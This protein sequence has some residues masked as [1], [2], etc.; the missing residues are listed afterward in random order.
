MSSKSSPN[1]V[2]IR[3][4]LLRRTARHERALE[5]VSCKA[6]FGSVALPDTPGALRDISH[7]HQ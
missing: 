7:D 2:G 3:F 6:L 4:E 1:S 5:G